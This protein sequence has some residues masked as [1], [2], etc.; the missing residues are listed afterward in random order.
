MFETWDICLEAFFYRSLCGYSSAAG[1]ETLVSGTY[2][3]TLAA[4]ESAVSGS[5]PFLLWH[6]PHKVIERCQRFIKSG[7]ADCPAVQEVTISSHLARLEHMAATR[8]RIV[9]DQADAKRQFDAA[10]LQL[11]GRTYRSS[12]PGKFLRDW[13][14]STSPPRRWLEV[15]IG[16]LTSLISQMT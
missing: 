3:P 1:Q 11:A 12:R 5:R 14:T 2:Y 4:A 6:N 7:Q 16:E 15:T 10:T 13:D 8:H 9:H